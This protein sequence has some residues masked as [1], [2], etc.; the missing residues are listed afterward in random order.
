MF[1]ELNAALRDLSVDDKVG[2]VVL[3][4]SEKAFAAGADIKEM[5]DKEFAEVYKTD[6]L[7]HWTELTQFRKPIVAAVSGYAVSA[8]HTS[9][10]ICP[11]LRAKHVL[12][13]AARWRLRACYDVRVAFS[14]RR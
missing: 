6:F 5:K 11:E 7:A 1:H 2:A 10:S 13:P 14:I 8:R 9:K 4:G 12:V 3:T